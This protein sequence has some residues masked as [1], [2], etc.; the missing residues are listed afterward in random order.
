MNY[1]ILLYTRKFH[2]SARVDMP[3]D[4]QNLLLDVP[5]LMQ[6]LGQHTTK[7]LIA[8]VFS[9]H[10]LVLNIRL[11]YLKIRQSRQCL[12]PNQQHSSWL[13]PVSTVKRYTGQC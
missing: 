8:T 9:L 7:L 5:C 6:R 4:L 1:G 10:Y 13:W 3:T 2:D 12:P 11:K